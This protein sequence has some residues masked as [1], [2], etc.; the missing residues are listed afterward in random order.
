[1]ASALAQP[2]T[3]TAAVRSLSICITSRQA[4]Q[5]YVFQEVGYIQYGASALGT[6]AKCVLLVSFLFSLRSG[7][8]V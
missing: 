6:L 2:P 1:M 4:G 7:F 5:R 3:G 8:L